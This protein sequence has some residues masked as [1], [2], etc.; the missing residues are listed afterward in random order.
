MVNPTG[1]QM[2]LYVTLAL[3]VIAAII[4]FTMIGKKKAEK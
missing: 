4:C 3:Y 1:Y 2:V